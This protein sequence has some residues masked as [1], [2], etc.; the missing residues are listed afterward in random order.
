MK[1]MGKSSGGITPSVQI[2]AFPLKSY[3]ILGE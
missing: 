1:V 3:V 2:L